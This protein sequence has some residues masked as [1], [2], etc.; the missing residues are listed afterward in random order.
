MNPRADFARLGLIRAVDRVSS[1]S[2]AVF[3]LRQVANRRP[4][5]VDGALALARRGMRLVR[6]KRA[7]E[8][9]LDTGR[10]F[11][12]PPMVED[13]AVLAADI[14]HAGIAAA[15]VQPPRSIDVRVLRDK[16]SLSREPFATRFG[17]EVE[18]LRNWEIGRREPDTT[19]RSYLHAIANGPE[20]VEQACAPM[21]AVTE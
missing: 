6:A 4:R 7:M 5:T 12:D 8:E 9:L 20:R 1:G 21:K 14:A 16:L 15:E 10:S 17:L 3:V 11:V 18:T 19:A 2:P 13:A